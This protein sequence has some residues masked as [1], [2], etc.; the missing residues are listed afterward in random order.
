MTNLV[1]KKAVLVSFEEWKHIELMRSMGRRREIWSLQ[2]HL[3][4]YMIMFWVM[5][6]IDCSAAGKI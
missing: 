6:H 2:G 5:Y 3:R 1:L 4:H